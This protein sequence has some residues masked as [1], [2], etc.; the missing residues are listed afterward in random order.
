MTIRTI[1][2]RSADLG[3]IRILGVEADIDST[4][5]NGPRAI[6]ARLVRRRAANDIDCSV[7]YLLAALGRTLDG[8]FGLASGLRRG[9]RECWRF[10]IRQL[11]DTSTFEVRAVPRLPLKLQIDWRGSS[12]DQKKKK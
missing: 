12:Q 3:R 9:R 5:I 4:N 10:W 7:D 6:L 2:D 1:A 8:T 11:G